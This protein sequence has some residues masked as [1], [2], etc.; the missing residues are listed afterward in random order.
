[1]SEASAGRVV[2]IVLCAPSL[3]AKSSLLQERK[4]IYCYRF[5]P[6]TPP[7]L[8]SSS[9]L[10]LVSFMIMDAVVEVGVIVYSMS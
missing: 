10:T 8:C 2:S 4:A 1:M 7:I 3:R 6:A 5:A 9:Y